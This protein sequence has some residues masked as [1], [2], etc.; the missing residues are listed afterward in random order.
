MK[1]ILIAT[2]MILSSLPASSFAKGMGGSGFSSPGTAL[3]SPSASPPA[4]FTSR[5]GTVTGHIGQLATTTVPGEA[6]Q[7]MLIPNGN[8]T[9]TSIGPGGGISTVQTPR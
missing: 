8:G 5:G 6:G 3:A 1:P 4:L 2:A 9:S 7:G